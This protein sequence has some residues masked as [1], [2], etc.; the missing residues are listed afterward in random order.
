M[1]GLI[2]LVYVLINA[3]TKG[4]YTTSLR[5]LTAVLICAALAGLFLV[6]RVA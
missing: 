2:C 1:I 6:L 4:Y 3:A 5:F